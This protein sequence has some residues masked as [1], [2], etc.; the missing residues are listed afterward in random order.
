M[1]EGYRSNQ[2]D[3]LE[4]LLIC[5]KCG[6][7]NTRYVRIITLEDHG[8]ADCSSCNENGPV[9]LFLPKER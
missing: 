4:A 5:P 2:Q 1:I 7:R 6:E 3:S 8:S 9:Q